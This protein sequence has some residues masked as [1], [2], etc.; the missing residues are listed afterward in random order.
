MTFFVYKIGFFSA[1]MVA[2]LFSYLVYQFVQSIRLGKYL[3]EIRQNLDALHQIEKKYEVA[4]V[5]AEHEEYVLSACML[6]N[7]MILR[8]TAVRLAKTSRDKIVEIIAN[9]EKHLKKISG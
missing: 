8:S 6:A 5:L 4:D 2:F 9:P 7:H 3:K 1:A